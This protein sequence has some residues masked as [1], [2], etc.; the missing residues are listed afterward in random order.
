MTECWTKLQNLYLSFSRTKSY[1]HTAVPQKIFFV[2]SI[3]LIFFTSSTNCL[4]LSFPGVLLCALSCVHQFRLCFKVFCKWCEG[5]GDSCGDR[6]VPNHGCGGGYMK[7]HRGYS[8]I[9]CVYMC[10]HM[11]TQIWVHVKLVK[12]DLQFVSISISWFWHDPIA[13]QM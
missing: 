3:P 2:C 10:T 13:I 12:W 7:T 1:S 4:N 11:H 9:D 5:T 6:I 8:K